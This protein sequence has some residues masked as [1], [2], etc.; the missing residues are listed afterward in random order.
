MQGEAEIIQTRLTEAPQN[1]LKRRRLFRDKQDF[2]PVRQ[3]LGDD[4]GN[5]L[6]FARSRRAL[7]DKTG[8]QP[9]KKNRLFLAG[10]RVDNFM[11]L[12]R[13]SR[14][15]ICL[16]RSVRK[17]RKR[18]P[19]TRHCPQD[20]VTEDSL[21]VVIEVMVHA[22]LQEG[23]QPETDLADNPP[24][25]PVCQFL[26]LCQVLL[27]GFPVLQFKGRQLD[28]I[29]R[30]KQIAQ[31]GVYFNFI[32]IVAQGIRGT[33]GLASQRHGH[34]EHRRFE[35]GRTFPVLFTPADEPET[36]IK[37]V[38]SLLF[39]RQ[40]CLGPE[41]LQGLFPLDDRPGGFDVAHQHIQ[42]IVKRLHECN[43]G[44]RAEIRILIDR[45]LERQRLF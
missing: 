32:F 37:D 14:I 23:K 7:H 13:L 44:I 31:R 35:P 2:L 10:V 28:M 36:D 40:F 39:L 26:D 15:E 18:L 24:A 33:E 4:I 5:G 43:H 21:L 11:P 19:V 9:G 29:Q 27:N 42:R 30:I 8:P 12:F 20:R 25:M 1:H 41:I 6:A 22:D 45:F 38:C 17:I 3:R 16:F 34:H